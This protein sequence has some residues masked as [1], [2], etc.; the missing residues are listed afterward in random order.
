VAAPIANALTQNQG[1]RILENSSRIAILIPLRL[2]PIQTPYRWIPATAHSQRKSMTVSLPYAFD[3]G[4]KSKVILNGICVLAAIVVIPGLIKFLVVAPNPV[5]ALGIACIGGFLFY[6]GYVVVKQLC[7]ATGMI[8]REEILIK[9]NRFLSIASKEPEGRFA[10]GQFYG[11]LVKRI[12]FAGNRY[13]P[14]ERVLL[15]GKE[16]TPNIL[17]ARTRKGAGIALGRE[18]GALLN[19]PMEERI[20]PY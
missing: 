12:V 5:A 6:F 14:H 4:S 10:L 2:Q 20:S 17:I 11:L 15:M 9:P 7:G 3:T 16:N 19:L 13:S 1:G 18:L 8:T